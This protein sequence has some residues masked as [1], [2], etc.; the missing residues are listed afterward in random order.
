MRKMIF[1]LALVLLTVSIASAVYASGFPVQEDLGNLVEYADK[2]LTRDGTAPENIV[3]HDTFDAGNRLFALAEIDG[4]LGDIRLEKGVTGQYKINSIGHGTGNFRQMIVEG[5]NGK[6]YLMGVRNAVFGIG[7]VTLSI[8]GSEYTLEV[9]GDA[10]CSFVYTE[11]EPSVE[12]LADVDL[13]SIRF[14]TAGGEDI[15]DRVWD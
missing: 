11:V 15:T 7:T 12:G 6:Y 3:I 8:G 14:Y 10:A 2:F 5:Q 1:A 4:E 9:S 13:E